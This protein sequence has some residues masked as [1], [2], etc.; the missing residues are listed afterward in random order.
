MLE[1]KNRKYLGGKKLQ[2]ERNTK[3]YTRNFI[4]LLKSYLGILKID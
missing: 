3:N 2:K 4:V 1:W